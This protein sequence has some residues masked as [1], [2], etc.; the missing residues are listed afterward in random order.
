MPEFVLLKTVLILTS[1]KHKPQCFLLTAN[2]NYSK[3]RVTDT[4]AHFLA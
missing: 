4:V 3:T 2:E 1:F